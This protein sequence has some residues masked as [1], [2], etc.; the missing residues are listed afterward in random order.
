MNYDFD[1]VI[2]RENTD[3]VKYDLRKMF[4]GK[5]DVIPMWVADMDFR[6]PQ[7]ILDAIA[8]RLE[9]PILGYSFRNEDY[10]DAITQ[11]LK[12]RHDWDVK[13]EW[14]LFSPGVVPALNMSVLA[15]T[16]PRAKVIIQPPVYTPFFS[17]VKDNGRSILLN[18]LIKGEKRYEIDFADLQN[19]CSKGATMI[20]IS[21]PHNPGGMAWT[22]EELKEVAKICMRFGVIIVSDEI[23]C[24]LVNRGYKHTVLASISKKIATQTVTMVAASKTFNLAGL[25][26]ASVI[27]S[28]PGLRRNYNRILQTLHLDFGNLFGPVATMAAYRHGEE[29]LNE[30]LDYIHENINVL[31]NYLQQNIP[32]I[33]MMRPEATY[34]AWL[35]CSDLKMTSKE[36][37]HLF[38]E[39]AGLGLNQG[40]DFGKA[41]LGFMRINLACPRQVLLKALDQLKLAVGEL[42][43]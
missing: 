11:W 31:Q 2:N 29:W 30:L 36:L 24:D 8:K 42:S 4:F 13:K 20:L 22:T 7:F 35:D 34:M 27:I 1:S 40:I 23:H 16:R 12:R 19:K 28:D 10:Y 18:K 9:H 43:Q 37:R 14:I 5:E 17:A 26:T 38:I 15:F 25:S 41:G 39:K 21:N 6:T 33:K 3:S 32:Q